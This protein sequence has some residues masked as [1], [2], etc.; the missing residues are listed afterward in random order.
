MLALGLN[1]QRDNEKICKVKQ[2]TKVKY[3][4][5]EAFEVSAAK[6]RFKIRYSIDDKAEMLL[7]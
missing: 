5:L 7:C 3:F 6:S 2:F 1:F 4:R